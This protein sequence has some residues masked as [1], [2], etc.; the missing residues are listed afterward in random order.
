LCQFPVALHCT[1]VRSPHVSPNCLPAPLKAVARG[2][3][4]LVHICIRS[5]ST[6]FPHLH[7]L[8]SPPT[9]TPTH[10]TYFTVLSCIINSKANGQRGFSMYPLCEC[11][12]LCLVQCP[13]FLSLTPSL[14]P[15]IIQQL[16]VHI[17]RSSTC[18][19]VMYFD[20]ID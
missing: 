10:C 14:P 20:I 12:L 9:S 2:F 5:P 16:S 6:I 11:T 18:T 8:Y 4:V 3:I 15:P 17:V 13:L 19:D 7:L 1:L